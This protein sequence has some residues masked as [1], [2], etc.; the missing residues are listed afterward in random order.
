MLVHA[1]VHLGRSLL[2][3]CRRLVE[4]LLA[5]EQCLNLLLLLQVEPGYLVEH[6][7]V[8]AS[9]TLMLLN[10]DLLLLS[11]EWLTNW[12]VLHP[13]RSPIVLACVRITSKAAVVVGSGRCSEEAF[14]IFTFLTRP[15]VVST[16]SMSG[17]RWF[18]RLI[19]PARTIL[20]SPLGRWLSLDSRGRGLLLELVE[21]IFQVHSN[22]LLLFR[23]LL[24]W[25][26]LSL[27]VVI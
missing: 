17:F 23:F 1:L 19:F 9:A 16:L 5:Q 6:V 11:N 27:V 26:R 3:H 21:D 8:E 14:T 25:S 7:R 12:S 15:I 13:V 10:R 24:L 18:F 4:C 20:V 2:L 22:L